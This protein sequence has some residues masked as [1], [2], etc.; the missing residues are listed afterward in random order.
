[1]ESGAAV[2]PQPAIA[3]TRTCIKETIKASDAVGWYGP[4]HLLT[5]GVYPLW[6]YGARERVVVRRLHEVPNHIWD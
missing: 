6:P 3:G 2:T 4:V 1:M 5:L